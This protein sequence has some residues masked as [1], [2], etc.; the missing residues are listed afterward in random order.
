MT[1]R[2]GT[3]SLSSFIFLGM[4]ACNS[5]NGL[6]SSSIE[7]STTTVPASN[8]I[9]P[10]PTTSASG[11]VDQTSGTVYYPPTMTG[12]FLSPSTTGINPAHGQPGHDCAVAVGAPLN[13]AA[14]SVPTT[15]AVNVPTES[16]PLVAST[17]NLT[18]NLKINPAH[19]QPG[20]D[21]AVAVGA[22][23]DGST[24]KTTTA[25]TNSTTIQ[26]EPQAISAGASIPNF[27]ANLKVNPAHGKPGHDCAVAVGAPLPGK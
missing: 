1:I 19:G 27:G 26:T 23:L 18:P 7:S 5:D 3:L 12:Q 16:Q 25:A 14:S 10:P 11:S 24:P 9:V 20:H 13:K 2:K 15:A 6:Q 17:P 22:P 21:C 8:V 4:V